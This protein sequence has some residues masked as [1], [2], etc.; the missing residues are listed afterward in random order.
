MV[1]A[2]RCSVAFGRDATGLIALATYPAVR[3]RAT[4]RGGDDE[5]A[6]YHFLIEMVTKA[7]VGNP[8]NPVPIRIDEPVGI[9]FPEPPRT[10]EGEIS[11]D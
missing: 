7:A 6:L 10:S 2:D 1:N 9:E 5:L 11:L 4:S 3:T 8:G